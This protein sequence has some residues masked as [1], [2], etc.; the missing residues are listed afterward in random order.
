MLYVAMLKMMKTGLVPA[1]DQGTI[2]VFSYNPPAASLNR[3]EALTDAIHDHIAQNPNVKHIVSFTGLDFMTFAEKT[4]A[5]ATI[6]KL[7]HWNERKDS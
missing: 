4:N 6:V 3:T 5:A 1:E 2:F 7:N